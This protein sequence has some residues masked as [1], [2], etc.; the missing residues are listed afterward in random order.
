MTQT[1]RKT[2]LAQ[3]P[4]GV[5]ALGFVSLLMDISSEMIHALL[6]V[7]L[8]S[9]FSA[10]MAEIGIIEGIAEATAMIV[11]VFSGAVSDWLG[12]RKALAGLGYSLAAFTKPVFPLAATLGWVIAAR[13]IDRVGKGIRGA[14]R[15]ALVADIAPPHLR[16]AAFGLRQSLDTVGAFIGPAV[17]VWLMWSSRNDFRLVFWIAV[18][19]A[20]LAVAVL[21]LA[22]REPERPHDLRKMRF[23]L[24]WNELRR[25]G[26]AYWLIVALAS[27]FALA[28]FSEAFLILKARD[29]GL[30]VALTPLVLVGMNIVYSGVSYPVG[31]WSDK[32]NRLTALAVGLALL[33]AG[34]LALANAGSIALVAAGVALWGAHMGFT[35]G[36][37]ATLVA[38]VAAPDLRGT[39]FGVFNLVSGVAT[40]AASVGAGALWDIYGSSATF[41]CGAA[42]AGAALLGLW[43]AKMREP[44]L[45]ARG[46]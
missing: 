29:A 10:S 35:Q 46:T 24:H 36:L 41:Y 27:L 21:F 23:P 44:S 28:R 37:L 34:D 11:K 20:F 13:F 6:P 3:L 7:Y 12:K 38:D 30:A 40:L 15:D 2:T 39:A 1:L 19:P 4:A 25:L 45:G 14:P 8:V 26:G 31:A 33:I 22:V 18:I 42:L 9:V 17:A 5:W 32:R 43:L 16:G